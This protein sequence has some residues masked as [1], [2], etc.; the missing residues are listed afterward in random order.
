MPKF[1]VMSDIHGFYNEMR[2]ALD[3]AGF[4]ENNEEHWIITCGDHFDRGPNPV[5]VMR[6]LR[7]LPR[8]I[9]VR[10]NHE[11]LLVNCCENG[12]P[13]MHDYHN[14]TYGTICEIGDA[15]EGYDFGECCYRTLA[16]THLFLESMVDYLETKNY[17]FVH[18]WI[19]LI[20]KDGL[21]SHYTRN[22]KFEFN[23]NW[24]EASA[25]EWAD[26]RWGN[27]F[28][29]AE[30]GFL[31]DK[32][33]IFGHWHCSTGWA[34]AEGRSEFGKDAKFDPYYGDGFIAIDACTAHS[35]KCNVLVL[36]D[37]FLEG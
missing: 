27:P 20:S 26:S 9:L 4:D 17:I 21:P 8:K 34:K 29:L 14:G 2:K 23:P 3:E 25:K 5:E 7:T 6:Y 33:V 28:E 31:P 18:S 11:E 22:R 12:Y 16:K 37:E 32:T 1:F 19:P 35:G 13:G 10:G 15:G 24:R 36:E 30:Q